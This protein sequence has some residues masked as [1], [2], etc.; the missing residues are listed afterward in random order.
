[1]KSEGKKGYRKGLMMV[2]MILT[3]IWIL[4]ARQIITEIMNSRKHLSAEK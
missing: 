3:K 1:M 2:V 4:L